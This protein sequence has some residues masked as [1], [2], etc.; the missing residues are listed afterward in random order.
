MEG[1]NESRCELMS[2]HR[3]RPCPRGVFSALANRSSRDCGENALAVG[4]SCDVRDL[5]SLRVD[6]R[7]LM[8]D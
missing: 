7:V 4:R 6:T 3:S 1:P 2:V 5:L 8:T